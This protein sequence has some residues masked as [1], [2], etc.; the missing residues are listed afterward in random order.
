MDR[1]ELDIYLLGWATLPAMDGYSVLSS[2]LATRGDGL[3]GNNPNG[4]SDPRLDQLTRAAAVEIDEP[5][6]RQLLT[7]A[8]K[9][10]RDDALYLPLHQ[11]PVAFAARANIEAINHADEFVRLW[12]AKVN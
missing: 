7:D 6:R 2:L 8:L 5:K 9:I 4:L 10:V 11:L 12:Y 1:G 3:G